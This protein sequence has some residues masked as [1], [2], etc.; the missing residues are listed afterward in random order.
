[1]SESPKIRSGRARYRARLGERGMSLI[2]LLLAMTVLTIGMLGSMILIMVGMQSNTRNKTDSTA[3][4]LDQEILEMFATLNN[5]PKSGAVTIFDCGLTAGAVNQHNAALTWGAAPAG[6]GATVYTAA[7][8]PLPSQV[9]EID[10]TQPTPT[11][12][13]SAV[14][15]YAMRYQACNGDTYEVRWNVMQIDP[16]SRNSL[17]TVSSRQLAAQGSNRAMLFAIPTTLRTLIEN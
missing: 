7:T 17:L 3:V 5:Y 4:V 16:N 14:T 8:A 1:M 15:G 13:T 2:E 12:A 9:G 6:N 10:W 11:L